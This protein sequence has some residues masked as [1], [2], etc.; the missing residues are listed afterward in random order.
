MI[1]LIKFYKVHLENAIKK[2]DKLAIEYYKAVLVNL[3]DH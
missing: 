2:N 1:N 3:Q